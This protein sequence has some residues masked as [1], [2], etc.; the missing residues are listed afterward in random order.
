M[1]LENNLLN[2]VKRKRNNTMYKLYFTSLCLFIST[3]ILANNNSIEPSLENTCSVT[4]KN[5]PTIQIM[6]PQ[7]K[8]MTVY[9]KNE[10]N[11]L[12]GSVTFKSESSETNKINAYWRWKYIEFFHAESTDHT[13]SAD[14]PTL[15]NATGMLIIDANKEFIIDQDNEHSIIKIKCNF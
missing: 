13:T 1:N 9:S 4:F 12:G 2:V 11:N 8:S 3:N 5:E 15:V 10:S 6:L 14:I 7:N